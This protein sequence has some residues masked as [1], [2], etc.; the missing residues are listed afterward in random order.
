MAKVIDMWQT[1]C[2]TPNGLQ[3]SDEGLWVIDA[4]SNNLL[5]LDWQDGSTLFEA[6]TETYKA[7]GLTLSA[8]HVWVAS[9]H[10]S[11]LYRLNR[12]GSTDAYYDSPGAGVRDP[13][14]VGAD[15]ARPHGMEWVDGKLWVC[16]KPALRIYQLDPDTM[17]VLHWIPTPGPAPHG[18]AWDN[19]A[20]WCNEKRERK[21][22]KLDAASG[23][24]LAELDVPEPE[25][26]G[27]TLHDGALIFC[28]D[29]SR[30]VCRIEI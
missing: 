13:R 29:A 8:T 20:L 28:G 9:T 22:H 21:I 11:R 25:L 14:D 19:G 6:P 12:D 15:Y 1:P 30:R 27:L 26:D 3:A 2:Q 5:L 17:E 7:S 23:A 16:V 4:A 10:N 24:V 18:I